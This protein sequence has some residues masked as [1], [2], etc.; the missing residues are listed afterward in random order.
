MNQ[1]LKKQIMTNEKKNTK[2]WVLGILNDDIN[3]FDYVIHLLITIC[4]LDPI[5][6]EKFTLISHHNG[7]CDVKKGSLDEM[8]DLRDRLIDAGLGATVELEE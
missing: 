5:R 3:D 1:L 2:Q 6:A 4:K 8:Q 7:R